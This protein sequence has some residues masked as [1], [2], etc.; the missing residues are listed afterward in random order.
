[1][2]ME[3]PDEE[4]S[5]RVAHLISACAGPIDQLNMPT[6]LSG[7]LQIATYQI[8]KSHGESRMREEEI[9]SRLSGAYASSTTWVLECLQ[10]WQTH[11]LDLFPYDKYGTS[12]NSEGY[13]GADFSLLIRFG[14]DFARACIFQA[15]VTESANEV[16]VHRIA[17][18]IAAKD[19]LPEK[20][21]DPQTLR[22]AEY[23]L[24]L[25]SSCAEE[26]LDWIHL[27][28]YSPSSF[29]CIPLNEALSLITSYKKTRSA[30]APE[31]QKYREDNRNERKISSLLRHE[32]ER[33]YRSY[34]GFALS[35]TAHTIELVHLLAAGASIK[36]DLKAPGW[37]NLAS[38]DEI[39]DFK[40]K[41]PPEVRIIELS[42]SAAP[43]PSPSH[44]ILD[45][46]NQARAGYPSTMDFNPVQNLNATARPKPGG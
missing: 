25:S 28:A 4:T 35:R 15:K 29:Y 23:G 46:L 10:A 13:R 36:P 3:W 6:P 7:A 44:L 26:D 9:T 19:G 2:S 33:L 1:M 42:G 31:L 39:R 18:F 24:E 20:L 34:D 45:S 11:G 27:C 22:L 40:E 41:C 8:L 21:P 43:S 12:K 38:A 30:I 32:A 5:R 17:P 16:W 14:N 37:L